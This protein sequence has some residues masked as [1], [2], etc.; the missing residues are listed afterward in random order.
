MDYEIIRFE[1]AGMNS[2][3][4]EERML[5]DGWVINLDRG[6]SNRA[7]SV[8]PVYPSVKPLDEKVEYC[9][10]LFLNRK[11]TPVFR[12][13]EIP[14]SKRLREFLLKRGY[15]DS[16]K[17][18]VQSMTLSVDYNVEYIVECSTENGEWCNWFMKFYGKSEE[19]AQ[20]YFDIIKAIKLPLYLI[21]KE[22][23][24]E[25]AACGMG[26]LDN[27]NLGLFNIAVNPDLRGLGIGRSVTEA[28]LAWGRRGGAEN[29]WLQVE[30]DNRVANHI[31][32]KTGF[33]EAYRY[34][35]MR[36]DI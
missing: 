7:N 30:T 35:Y 11:L 25:I 17:I 5:F 8:V 3:P 6:Y 34:N 15:R 28:I 33:I 2:W 22:H 18:S 36:K 27:K 10:K 16:L 4:A 1:E 21:L 13:F 29:A 31:Y 9:E 26:V 20:G 32:R 23:N 24:G 12:V 14:E 19:Q